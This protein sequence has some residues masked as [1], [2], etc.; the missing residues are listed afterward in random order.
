MYGPQLAGWVTATLAGGPPS[1]S[2]TAVDDRA[3]EAGH[4]RLG[5]R[6]AWPPT[7]I[8]DGIADA[9]LELAG[10][11]ARARSSARRSAASPT[12]KLPSSRRNTTD[13]IDRGA[14][15]E[16]DDLDPSVAVRRRRRCTSCR[17]RRRGRRPPLHPPRSG[18]AQALSDLPEDRGLALRADDRGDRPVPTGPGPCRSS[19]WRAGPRTASAA[20]DLERLRVAAPAA[21]DPATIVCVVGEFKQGKSSLVNALLGTT[22]ARSTTTSPLGHHAGPPR[23]R[24]RRGRG[25]SRRTAGRPDGRRADRPSTTSA[26]WVTESRQPRQRQ[27]RRSASTSPSRARCSR[28]AG[29]SSTRPGWAGSAPGHAAATLAFLPFADGLVFV[30]DAAP[31]LSAPEVAFLAHGRERCPT[32]VVRTDEDRPLREWRDIARARRGAPRSRRG[33]RADRWRCRRTCGSA[34]SRRDD[35]ELDERAGSPRC[36]TLLRDEVAP[37][38]AHVGRA[39]RRPR[40][41]AADS[42]SRAARGRASSAR[43]P[44]RRRSVSVAAAGRGRRERLEHLRGR[45]RWQRSS[46]TA[47]PTSRTTSTSRLPGRAARQIAPA[48]PRTPS[49]D[50]DRPRSGTTSAATSRAGGATAVADALL[51]RDRR[52]PDPQARAELLGRGRRRHRARAVGPA[53]STCTRSGRQAARAEAPAAARLGEASP[54]CAAPRAGSSCSG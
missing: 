34:P 12:R 1:R 14:V 52:R 8:G 17:G 23:G 25:P 49:S 20:A 22:C 4:E 37:G 26:D 30:S 42:S 15:A 35:R 24:A 45:A 3:Q 5:R 31:E 41:L 32:V 46:A 18:A 44:A 19:T 47:S 6:T 39:A 10:D 7:S 28:R 50:Q 48:T 27:G 29:A 13:G 43:R 21:D 9:A 40:S 38:D 53:R 16:G 51:H 33:R 36:S 54:G 2:M 11:P